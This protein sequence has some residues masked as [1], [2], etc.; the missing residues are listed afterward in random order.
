MNQDAEEWRVVCDAPNY[1][2]SSLGRVRRLTYAPGTFVGRIL[3]QS[4]AN[5]Y[6]QLNLVADGKA[7]SRKVHVLVCTAFHG[8]RPSVLHQAAHKDGNRENNRRENLRWAL[9]AE[10]AADDIENG[11]RPAGELH[12]LA[13]LTEED[14][15][16]IRLAYAAF[17]K[18]VAEAHGIERGYVRK[19]IAGDTWR[20]RSYRQPPDWSAS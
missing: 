4:L 16:A 10:N 11:V 14:V 7:R 8:P 15:K 3:S 17:I 13:R 18:E 20:D 12:P 2:V 1:E 6:K 5:G 19:I 9:P